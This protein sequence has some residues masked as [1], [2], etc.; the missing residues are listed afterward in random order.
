MIGTMSQ[1][2]RRPAHSPQYLARLP[3]RAANKQAG[4]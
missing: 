1:P 3:I 4:V 2:E